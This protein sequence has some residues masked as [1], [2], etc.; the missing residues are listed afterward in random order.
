MQFKGVY[1]G[2][3]LCFAYRTKEQPE[4]GLLQW[5]VSAESNT[6]DVTA[7]WGD[8]E[9]LEWGKYPKGCMNTEIYISSGA[10]HPLSPSD[11]EIRPS[12]Q[13]LIFPHL[14][15]GDSWPQPSSIHSSQGLLSVW[16]FFK[17]A[18]LY[19]KLSFS[20]QTSAHEI[21]FSTSAVWPIVRKHNGLLQ[22]EQPR[23]WDHGGWQTDVSRSSPSDCGRQFL[24]L[25][26][27]FCVWEKWGIVLLWQVR[28]SIYVAVCCH[29]LLIKGK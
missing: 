18:S 28:G 16:T 23:R 13:S 12:S 9:L 19:I 25:N 2:R 11:A 1:L 4:S 20:T 3:R 6:G 24:H 22:P 7:L 29:K 21:S 10:V 27:C 5:N 15:L 14:Q 26:W 17:E 8:R